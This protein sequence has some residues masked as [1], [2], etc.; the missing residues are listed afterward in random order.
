VVGG[1]DHKWHS[2]SSLAAT[3]ASPRLQSLSGAH[4][5]ALHCTHSLLDGALHGTALTPGRHL[6]CHLTLFLLLLLLLRV[7]LDDVRIIIDDVSSARSRIDMGSQEFW[8][9]KSMG[10][11]PEAADCWTVSS[12]DPR[13]A[14]VSARGSQEYSQMWMTTTMLDRK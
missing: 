11:A 7:P 8:F 4:C 10:A 2:S 3:L 14:A 1:V 12:S 5:T 9:R 13:S 6:D